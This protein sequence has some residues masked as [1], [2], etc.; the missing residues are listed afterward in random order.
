[1]YRTCRFF[2]SVL[3]SKSLQLRPP[4]NELADRTCSLQ[5]TVRGVGHRQRRGRPGGSQRSG[6]HCWRRRLRGFAENMD[7]GA[8]RERRL[9]GRAA[10]FYEIW[11]WT[12]QLFEKVW[13][14]NT[15]GRVVLWDMCHRAA[16]FLLWRWGTGLYFF[17]SLFPSV[18]EAEACINVP[19]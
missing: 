17:F 13:D 7:M 14:D 3:T 4:T 11:N 10:H 1:M 2:Q 19:L 6:G 16:V 15:N 9:Q 8:I 18:H 12:T 5:P